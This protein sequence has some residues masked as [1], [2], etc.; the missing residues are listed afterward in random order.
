M[1]IISSNEAL[2]RIFLTFGHFAIKIN[3]GIVYAVVGFLSATA[4]HGYPAAAGDLRFA[5]HGV[6]FTFMLSK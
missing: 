6:Y 4:F 3:C 1:Q 5:P 2:H